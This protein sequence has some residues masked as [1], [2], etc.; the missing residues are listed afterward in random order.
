MQ[1]LKEYERRL[2]SGE[3]MEIEPQLVEA[4]LDQVRVGNVQL[5]QTGAGVIDGANAGESRIEAPYLQLV[6]TRLWDEENA[7]G[8]HVLRVETL[9]RLGGAER[10]VPA[11]LETAMAELSPAERNLSARIFRFLVTPSGTKIAHHV[12]DLADY[13]QVKADKIQPLLD[14]LSGQ[15]A[16]IL[17]GTGDGRY[18]IYHDVLAAAI[19]DWR[20][21]YLQAR[22]ARQ[23][24]RIAF[25]CFLVLF[26]GGVVGL[27]LTPKRSGLSVIMGWLLGLSVTAVVVMLGFWLWAVLARNALTQ[28]QRILIVVLFLFC[29]LIGPIGWLIFIVF[30]LSVRR[31][32]R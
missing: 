32:R 12:F 21:R 31:R 19:L 6:L 20:A 24:W 28:R 26:I 1:P 16:R 27:N 13:A 18:E 17:R 2:A 15:Q 8:S 11:H 30:W 4:I 29:L 9:D 23:R 10:I 14:R 7:A 25:A 22:A 3:H 5:G